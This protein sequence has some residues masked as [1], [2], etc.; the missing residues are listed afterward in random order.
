L[1]RRSAHVVLALADYDYDRGA[2]VQAIE[3]YTRAMNLD[4]VLV[5]AY[6]NRAYTHIRQ[7]DYPAALPDLDHAIALRPEYVNALM[8]RGDIY[9]YYFDIDRKRAAAYFG[10]NRRRTSVDAQRSFRCRT[11]SC[12]WLAVGI[13]SAFV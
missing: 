6:N 10:E 8:N 5:A 13:R 4:P 7:Q 2:C 11:E 12:G 1:S 3:D 9:N